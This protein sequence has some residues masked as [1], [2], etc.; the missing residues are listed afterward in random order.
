MII[1]GEAVDRSGLTVNADIILTAFLAFFRHAQ[2]AELPYGPLLGHAWISGTKFYVPAESTYPCPVAKSPAT[3]WT[4][5]VE[6]STVGGGGDWRIPRWGGESPASLSNLHVPRMAGPAQDACHVFAELA[7]PL[8]LQM[9]EE[10]HDLPTTFQ[11]SKSRKDA[12]WELLDAY[13]GDLCLRSWRPLDGTVTFFQSEDLMSQLPL[14]LVTTP[15]G[16]SDHQA[17]FFDRKSGAGD[18]GQPGYFVS[19]SRSFFMAPTLRW[20]KH[21][22]RNDLHCPAPG[23]FAEHGHTAELVCLLGEGSLTLVSRRANLRRRWAFS[24]LK[25][26]GSLSSSGSELLM[27]FK[28]HLHEWLDSEGR[29]T[30]KVQREGHTLMRVVVAD[31]RG[32]SFPMLMELIADRSERNQ[33]PL[34]RR[35]VRDR[36]QTIGARGKV[37]FCH[38]FV[39]ERSYRWAN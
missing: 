33:R 26:P 24:G 4:V 30:V 11:G 7:G 22:N 6:D 36:A 14:R 3:E 12:N 25:L 9:P 23:F 35:L 19:W 31:V 10:K 2:A 18:M 28:E 17:F 5:I 20:D 34:P 15:V 32:H 27:S 38:S 39:V 29:M 8:T 16:M 37:Q 21:G 13:F 1:V